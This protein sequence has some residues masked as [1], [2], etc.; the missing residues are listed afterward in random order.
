MNEESID[1]IVDILQDRINFHEETIE[2][3]EKHG[4]MFQTDIILSK[5]QIM[6]DTV[7]MEMVFNIKR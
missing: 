5:G 7:L 2:R 6:E 3:F 1:K 4:K